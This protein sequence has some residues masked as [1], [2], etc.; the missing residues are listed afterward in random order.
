MRLRPFSADLHIHSALSPCAEDHMRPNEVLRRIIS[1]GID[2]FSIT[3][4]NSGF[5]SAVFGEAVGGRE[6]LFIPGIE[7]QSAEEIHLLGYFPDNRALSSFCKAVVRP[8]L[9]QGVKN[10]PQRFGNQFK[11]NTEGDVTGEVEEMLSMPLSVPIDTL[12]DQIHHFN[13]IA[14]AAHLDKGF[15]VISHLGYI[16]AELRLDAVEI[17]DVEK[18]E[19]IRSKYLRERSLNIVSSS[20]AHHLDMMRPASTKLWLETGDVKSCIDCIKGAGPGR[21][22]ISQ[23]VRRKGLSEA[24]RSKRDWKALYEQS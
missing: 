23:K 20:D 14:V 19:I 21:I 9:V 1:L 24:H 16:P 15:S 12:V 2:V 4:H 6:I 10:D 17:M 7:L 13:G 22:T 3:D 8:G 18:I 11:L 5:N